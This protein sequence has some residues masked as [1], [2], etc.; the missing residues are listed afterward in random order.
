M[1]LYKLI[2]QFWGK[3]LD[4]ETTLEYIVAKDD[5]EVYAYLDK[6]YS[7][8]SDRD[9]EEEDGEEIY[10][11]KPKIMEEHNDFW[12]DYNGEFYDQKY[13]WKKIC[14]VTPDEI[15]TL[16]KLKILGGE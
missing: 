4:A 14:E 7:Y 6:N 2:T 1:Y 15:K 13:G 11:M 8:W 12:D 5:E 16:K 9:E 10:S 3:D